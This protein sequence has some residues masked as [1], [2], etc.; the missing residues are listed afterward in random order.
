[1]DVAPGE[2]DIG[3]GLAERLLLV[4]CSQPS[5]GKKPRTDDSRMT[6]ICL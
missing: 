5:N 2:L 6:L 1:L 4:T 3:G